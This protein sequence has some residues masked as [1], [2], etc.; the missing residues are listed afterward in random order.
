MVEKLAQ[1]PS[2]EL[3]AET[4]QLAIAMPLF[5][6]LALAFAQIAVMAFSV[7][8][9]S[10]QIEQAAWAV[11]VARLEQASSPQEADEIV[12]QAIAACSGA[13]RGGSVVV[14]N[15]AFTRQEAYSR[16]QVTPIL[17]NALVSDEEGLESYLLEELYR[18]TSAGLVEF[19]VSCELPTLVNLPGLSHV[20]VS[21]HVVR[22]RALSSR[23]EIR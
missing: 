13:T 16:S 4:V 1:R 11:D 22:E 19:D 2:P 17:N 9:L 14:S 6:L 7:L 21:R 23:T 5:L 8:T 15:S 18:E 20:R 12:S 10:G 3:G